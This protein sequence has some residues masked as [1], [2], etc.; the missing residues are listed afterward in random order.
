MPLIE[1]GKVKALA[2]SSPQ[3]LS[4]LKDIPTVGET[5]DGFYLQ[6][7]NGFFAVPNTPKD[8]IEKVSEVMRKAV[9]DPKIEG[10]LRKL[11]F[12][13]AAMTPEEMAKLMASDKAFYAKAVKEAGLT[14]Q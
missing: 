5:L 12:D 6:T 14:Q 2:I 13:P 8:I 10:Q 1:S 4:T 9:A 7:W 3:R 11:G